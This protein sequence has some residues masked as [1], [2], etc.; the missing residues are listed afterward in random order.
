VD[1]AFP[2]RDVER[3]IGSAGDVNS[4]VF[5]A[6]FTAPCVASSKLLDDSDSSSMTL[7]TLATTSNSPLI[8]YR[9]PLRSRFNPE[10]FIDQ[11]R[12]SEPLSS[13]PAL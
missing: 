13:T 12:L 5:E 9:R 1:R 10:F 11:K 8:Y 4:Y 7:T 2:S 3:W 6:S